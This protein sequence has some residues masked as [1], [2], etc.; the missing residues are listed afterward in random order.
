MTKPLAKILNY[1]GYNVSNKKFKK[2]NDGMFVVCL[3]YVCVTFDWF[4]VYMCFCCAF[5]DRKQE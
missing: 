4:V 5:F 1:F 3:L 2:Y